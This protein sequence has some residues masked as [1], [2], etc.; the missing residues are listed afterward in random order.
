MTKK[1]NIEKLLIDRPD[2]FEAQMAMI[3]LIKMNDKYEN[4]QEWK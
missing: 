2:L 4:S 1:K 3:Y